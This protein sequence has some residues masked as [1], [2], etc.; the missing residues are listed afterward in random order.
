MHRKG[1]VLLIGGA[2][3][4]AIAACA[5][6]PEAGKSCPLLCPQQSVTLRDTTVDAIVSDSTVNGLPSIGLETFM[7]LS[8]HRDT[9]DTRAI[10]RFDTI[11]QD[12]TQ[13]RRS[14]ARSRTS[15][16][17]QLVMPIVH[18]TLHKLDGADHDRSVQ[19][20]YDRDGYGGVDPRARCFVRIGSSARRRSRR[21][22]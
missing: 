11:Q 20:R 3:V 4:A 15:T 9:V 14:T 17:A 21:S 10:I 22:R 8:S 19:R 7:M 16:R 6:N 1:W 5:D 13:G 2:V 18:D 12:Y